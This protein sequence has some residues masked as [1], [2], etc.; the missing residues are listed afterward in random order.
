M[1]RSSQNDNMTF[2]IRVDNATIKD[3]YK[4]SQWHDGREKQ[5]DIKMRINEILKSIKNIRTHEHIPFTESKSFM[6][7]Q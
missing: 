5:Y 2:Y 7:C 4:V 6:V 1:S 3:V